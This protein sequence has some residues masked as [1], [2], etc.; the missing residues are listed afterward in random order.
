MSAGPEELH[1]TDGGPVRIHTRRPAGGRTEWKHR[2][3]RTQPTGA[4]TESDTTTGR[5]DRD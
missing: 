5:G 4:Y 2:D 1:G 3:P